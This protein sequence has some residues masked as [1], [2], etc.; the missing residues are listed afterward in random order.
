MIYEV[1]RQPLPTGE[2]MAYREA[3]TEEA[4]RTLLLI[5]GNQSSSLYY[6]F[7]M[8]EFSEKAH[9]FAVDMLGFG[10][11]SYKTPH[12]EMKDWADDV[13]LFMKEKKIE[14][15]VVLGWSAGGGA[16]MELA[17]CCPE[18]VQHLVLLASVGV[19][20]FLLPER[21]P[22]LTP[23][24]G[25]YLSERE[26]IIKDPAIMIPIT[27]AIRN[28]DSAFLRQVWEKTIFNLHCP[29]DEVFDAYMR[30]IL[31]ERCFTDISVALCRFN[32]TGEK[33]VTEGSGRI[34]EIRCPV[35]WVHG[36]ED[37]VVPFSTGEDSIRCFSSEAELEALEHAGHASFMDQPEK[38]HKIL[39]RVLLRYGR[40]NL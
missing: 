31:K 23:V 1:K 13:A 35:T 12:R 26:E 19:R 6:E 29:E 7:L 27:T 20:G 4:A 10:D 22:D 9:I 39:E 17:A 33:A 8:R 38:F 14:Q 18:R 37:L 5:H 40:E 36:K 3:G 21:N 28:Q 16:A 24:E 2:V 15:A 32:I 34:S 30:A 25:R 11:S